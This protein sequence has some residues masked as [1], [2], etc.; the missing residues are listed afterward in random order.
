MSDWGGFRQGVDQP[1]LAEGLFICTW[2]KV[3]E[4]E[5]E[6]EESVS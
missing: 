2:E 5:E 3:N 1:S 4:E 6:E